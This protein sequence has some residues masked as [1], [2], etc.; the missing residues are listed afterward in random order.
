[1]REAGGNSVHG[2]VIVSHGMKHDARFFVRVARLQYHIA[3][4]SNGT[5]TSEEHQPALMK[6]MVPKC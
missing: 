3:Y 2:I 1:M 4:G 6:A 5:F